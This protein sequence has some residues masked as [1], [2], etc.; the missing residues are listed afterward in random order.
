MFRAVATIL[1]FALALTSCDKP[2]QAARLTLPH[3]DKASAVI[4]YFAD[5]PSGKGP[6]PT[7]IFLH[8]HQ[9]PLTRVGGEAFVK[10]GVLKRFA[11]EGYLAV[12]VSLPG[13]GGL[14]GPEDFAGPFTQHA[15]AAV[16]AKL[17]SERQAAPDRILIEGISLGAVTAGLVAAHDPDIAGLVLISGLYD[18]PSF[19]AQP[20]STAAAVIK[21][22]ALKQASG[23]D[24]LRARSVLS[25]SSSIRAATLILNGAKD[26]RTDP[27]QARQ[28]AVAI[29]ANGGQAEVIIYPELGHEIPV[30]VRDAKISRFIQAT[31]KR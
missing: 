24:V 21:A 10:W 7:I 29:N 30:K 20:K 18:F 25:K 19:F 8:G 1:L 12:S 23:D 27:D 15:V 26:D 31:L 11:S 17:E 22:S 16:I 5:Q 2:L 13:Y 14:S 28:L 4:E 3:P 9:S 6:W